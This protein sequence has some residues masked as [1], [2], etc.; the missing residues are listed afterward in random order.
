M[1]ERPVYESLAATARAA[2]HTDV[3]ASRVHRWVRD[4]LLPATGRQIPLGRA[5]FRT[6]RSVAAEAQ[7]LALCKWRRHTKRLDELAVLMWADG[8]EVPTDRIRRALRSFLPR[9]LPKASSRAERARLQEQLEELA[10]KF[11]PRAKARF[12]RR[13]VQREEIAEALLP[14]LQRVAGVGGRIRN[15]DAEVIEQLT[16]Q[17]RARTDA[18]GGASPWLQTPPIESL[19]LATELSFESVAEIVS[20]VTDLDLERARPRLR[21]WLFEAPELAVR[22]AARGDPGFAGFHLFAM[23]RL[24][25]AVEAL[26]LMLFFDRLELGGN[27]DELIAD[28]SEILGR[29]APLSITAAAGR[30]HRP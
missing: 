7:L 9:S 10:Y 6:E 30:D 13:G 2:G 21:F 29:E 12:G 8:W 16:G 18:V 28:L 4:R 26:V 17:D 24:S 25:A 23:L 15:V 11:A 14:I 27:L 1:T 5:G 22:V 19:R 3:T 20:A